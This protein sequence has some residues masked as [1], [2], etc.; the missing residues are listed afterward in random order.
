MHRL[1]LAAA[2]VT[3]FGCSQSSP[4]PTPA[5]TPPAVT[6]SSVSVTGTMPTVGATT[7][8]SATAT[9]SN[10][11]AQTVTSQATW[12]S[13][14]TS[15][16]T[17]TNTGVVTAIGVGIA[18]ITATYQGAS[19]TSHVSVVRAT[20]TVSGHVTDGTSGGVLPNIMIQTVNSDNT[21]KSTLTGAAGD[22]AVGGILA[23]PVMVTASAISYQTTTKAVTVS[24]D[25]RIDIVLERAPP[26]YA[27]IWTGIYQ[28]TDCKDVDTSGIAPLL[29]V[30]MMNRQPFPGSFGY[31]F[32]LAQ[33]G[34]TVMGTYTLT[35]PMFDCPCGGDYGAFDMSGTVA[36][37]GSLV[38]SATG[39]PRATGLVAEMTFNL[40]QTSSSTLTGT[41]TGVLKFGGTVKATF[42]G[43]IV[44][45]SR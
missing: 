29:C 40:R 43:A 20:Y 41:L 19:G 26:T 30:Q 34:A 45:G 16:A 1:V 27:G 17:V 2:V 13:S 28:V 25:T 31:R 8:F 7:P 11:T 12:S 38:L 24:S 14:N 4:A 33:S 22:Y 35:T 5:P 39:T 10:G 32:T 36:S 3:L 6:V 44:S 23:G 21:T 9:L 18:D 37:D 15:V 42:S